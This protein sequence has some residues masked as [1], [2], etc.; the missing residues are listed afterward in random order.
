L[1]LPYSVNDP[2]RRRVDL[3]GIIGAADG[4]VDAAVGA[5]L[6]VHRR[7]DAEGRDICRRACRAGGDLPPDQDSSSFAFG[8]RSRNRAWAAVLSSW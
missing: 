6:V 5:R 2:P 4:D 1:W 3:V 8:I 7:D